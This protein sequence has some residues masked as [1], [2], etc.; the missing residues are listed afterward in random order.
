MLSP[1]S[2]AGLSIAP[3]WAL[4]VRAVSASPTVQQGAPQPSPLS[5]MPNLLPGGAGQPGG[6]PPS[7]SLPRGS[8]LDISV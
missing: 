7:Q 2:L 1:T 3:D 6:G 4:P 5:P 8:L